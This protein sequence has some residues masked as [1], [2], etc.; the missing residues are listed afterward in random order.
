MEKLRNCLEEMVKFTL[1]SAAEFD[2]GLSGDFCSAL[3]ADD[4][5][6]PFPL[7]D[8]GDRSIRVFP[9]EFS[10]RLFRWVF[11]FDLS[12]DS[13]VAGVP[14]YPLYK[15]L[16]FGLL[17]SITSGSFRGSYEKIALMKEESWLKEK[18]EEFGKLIF[19]KGSELVNVMKDIE[20][21]LP[22][23]EPFFSLMK[24]GLKTVEGTCFVADYDRLRPGSLVMLNKCLL[25]E[26][27]KVHHYSSFYEMLKAENPAKVFPGFTTAEEGMEIFGKFYKVD[28]EKSNS[29]V[30]IHVCKA[31]AQPC[32]ILAKI[33]SVSRAF[34]H[35]R[36][37]SSRLTSSKIEFIL[38][39]H[40]SV[41]TKGCKLSH[42]A[43]AL[44]KH[45]DRS[46]DR[47]WGILHGSDSDKNRQA[48]DIL[49]RLV[50]DCC[51]MNIHVVQPHGQVFEIR[52]A[53]GYG[54]RWSRDGT[55]FIGFLEPYMD[56]GHSKGWKH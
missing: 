49:S 31:A 38:F 29:V 9:Y 27:L 23:Q 19:E 30:A 26:V 20:F 10:A 28:Q 50:V 51:W 36:I 34:P 56:D 15:R 25:F 37:H 45:V 3:L 43:R 40:A 32:I 5:V 55:N 4:H 53:E 21:E 1:D 6:L 13:V 47:F 35:S 16:A 52:V 8:S 17:R 12:A 24:D 41:Q 39:I 18:E 44:A 42:G 33:L 46:S 22:V 7:A 14:E 54:A 2:L 48:A 11:W